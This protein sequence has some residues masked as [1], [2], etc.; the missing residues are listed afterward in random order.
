MCGG[1]DVCV[2]LGGG[3]VCVSGGGGREGERGGGGGAGMHYAGTSSLVFCNAYGKV[4]YSNL[5]SIE[6]NLE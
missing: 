5:P 2:C 3:D 6:V 1:G 4:L